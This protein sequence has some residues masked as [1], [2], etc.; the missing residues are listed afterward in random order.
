M[1]S[2]LDCNLNAAT[3]RDSSW[4]LVGKPF[5]IFIPH[6]VRSNITLLAVS[7]TIIG[8]ASNTIDVGYDSHIESSET[9][10]KKSLPNMGFGASLINIRH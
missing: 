1:D 9:D 10:H 8:N 2:T 3:L 4:Y 7:N 6:A 5:F